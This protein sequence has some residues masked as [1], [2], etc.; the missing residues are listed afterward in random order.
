MM[1]LQR[2]TLVQRV[3]AVK[4]N[5]A[6]SVWFRPGL[7]RLVDWAAISCRKGG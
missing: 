7:E 1:A 2:T 5:P 6:Q 4:M 3:P